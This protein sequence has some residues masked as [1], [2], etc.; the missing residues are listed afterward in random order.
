VTFVLREESLPLQFA[1]YL[2]DAERRE[3]WRGEELI[4]LE[5]QVLDLLLYLGLVDKGILK[6][7]RG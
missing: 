3:L 6:S 7:A 1:E 2:L 5:P 4:S